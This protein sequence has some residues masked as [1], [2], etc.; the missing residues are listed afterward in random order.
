MCRVRNSED[1]PRRLS[2][3]VIDSAAPWTLSSRA[4]PSIRCLRG[5]GVSVAPSTYRPVRDSCCLARVISHGRPRGKRVLR[6]TTEGNALPVGAAPVSHPV[7]E[8]CFPG[9]VLGSRVT[10][11]RSIWLPSTIWPRRNGPRYGCFSARGSPRNWKSSE[12][13]RWS[14][15]RQHS[16][17]TA[18]T[19]PSGTWRPR[20]QPG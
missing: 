20:D 10:T 12:P 19:Y 8:D 2:R 7:G 11:W 1:F 4:T 17:S 14:G 5:S 15:H 3:S 13:T 16:A 18:F 9:T 6:D